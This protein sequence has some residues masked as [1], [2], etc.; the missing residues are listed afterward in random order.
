MDLSDR[1]LVKRMRL[2]VCAFL[3]P[4]ASF[5]GPSTLTAQAVL[6]QNCGSCHA[7]PN[8]MGGLDIRTRES[9]LRG[10]RRGAA[11]IP[12]QAGKSLIIQAV[13]GAGELKMPPGRKLSSE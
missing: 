12:G 11:L 7:L 13:E 1:F 8:P 9:I 2:I 5:A 6:E 3:L 10:G 4:A